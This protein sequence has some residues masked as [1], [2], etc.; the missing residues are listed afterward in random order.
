MV[1]GQQDR[2]Q[3]VVEVVAMPPARRADRDHLLHVRH[4]RL[5]RL[6]LG[7]LDGIDNGRLFRRLL[8]PGR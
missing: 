4:L 1:G 5:E 6:L 8:A 3:N 2:R 7:D